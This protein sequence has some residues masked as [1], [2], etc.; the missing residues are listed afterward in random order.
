MTYYVH[1]TFQF[2]M[3]FSF[4]DLH[5]SLMMFIFLSPVIVS[6]VNVLTQ[7]LKAW[8]WSQI[9]QGSDSGSITSWLCDLK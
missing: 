2:N 9:E 5:A 4:A 3:T 6:Y 1:Y 7:T 8:I